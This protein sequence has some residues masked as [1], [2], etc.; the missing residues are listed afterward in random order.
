MSNYIFAPSPSFGMS[1]YPFVTYREAFNNDELTQLINH[2]DSLTTKR[3]EVGGPEGT[4]D[5]DKIRSSNIAWLGLNNDTQ[6]IYDRMA[7][8]A[9]ALNGQFYKFDLYGF[10][11][12]MQ[13][14]VYSGEEQN[15]YDW[16]VDTSPSNNFSP[17]KF[18]MVLQLSDPLEYVG[19]DLQILT[20]VEPV[21]V[22]KEKGL[23]AAF[24]SYVLHKVT[25]VTQGKRK[26]LVV[27]ICGPSFR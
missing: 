16:H 17:R 14:T 24:P 6:W 21:S 1:D 25:P 7:Y 10:N 20:S 18:S 4:V 9:R 27:W 12:D 23:I 5:D 8:V 11:E 3:G 13:Y 2:L 26:T 22:D 19:G 15:H